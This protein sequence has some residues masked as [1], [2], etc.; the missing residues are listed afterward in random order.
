MPEKDSTFWALLAAGL[1]AFGG[2]LRYYF[3]NRGKIMDIA[4]WS[5]A[6]VDIAASVF[7][8]I[9]VFLVAYPVTGETAAAGLAGYAGHIG[10]RNTVLFIRNYISRKR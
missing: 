5:E 10:T 8:G 4:W 3:A 6:L 2:Y 1:A 7:I 9:V